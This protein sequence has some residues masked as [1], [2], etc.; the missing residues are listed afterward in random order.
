MLPFS[1][2]TPVHLQPS[3]QATT[4]SWPREAVVRL[5]ALGPRGI[6]HVLRWRTLPLSV[7]AQQPLVVAPSYKGRHTPTA[8]GCPS[9]FWAPPAWSRALLAVAVVS[10]CAAVARRR[11]LR[12]RS[13]LVWE[14]ALAEW[15]MAAS[16]A[17]TPPPQSPPD[18]SHAPSAAPLG[19]EVDAFIG[20]LEAATIRRFTKGTHHC[21]W[22]ADPYTKSPKCLHKD[23]TNR[24]FAGTC[25]A[26]AGDAARMHAASFLVL[27]GASAGTTTALEAVGAARARVLAPNLYPATVHALRAHGVTAWLGDVCDLVLWPEPPPA[28]LR[29][30]GI[31]MDACGSAKRYV[32]VIRRLLGAPAADTDPPPPMPRLLQSGGVLAITLDHRDPQQ[33]CDGL[34]TLF[35]TVRSAAAKSGVRLEVL[36]GPGA[37]GAACPDGAGVGGGAARGSDS[38]LPARGRWVQEPGGAA[39]GGAYSYDGMFFVAFRVSDA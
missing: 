32:P 13:P 29:L 5:P 30:R 14:P 38:T 12:T 11:A 15:A 23:F 20:E 16:D 6:P 22:K 27:D 19:P 1:L 31:Y 17:A 24:L 25:A 21:A 36:T 2:A 28:G 4:A 7:G 33:G 9:S 35:R 34:T 3:A 39:G 37:E 26:A 10:G 18:A 8:S